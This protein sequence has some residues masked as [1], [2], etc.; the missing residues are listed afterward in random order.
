VIFFGPDE[1]TANLMDAGALRAKQR[2]YKYWKALTTGVQTSANK[3]AC[4]DH[5][6]RYPYPCNDYPYPC[7]DY[8]YPC[9]DY[10]YLSFDVHL[11]SA[12]TVLATDRQE[13]RARRC[14]A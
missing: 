11:M 14:A 7:Y 2:G 12:A 13:H 10:Q 1:N 4:Q 6:S 5:S 8:P 3:S 9:Y